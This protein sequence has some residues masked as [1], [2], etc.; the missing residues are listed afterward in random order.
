MSKPS[1]IR[2]SACPLCGARVSLVN[3]AWPEKPPA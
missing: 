1:K 2:A 3:G